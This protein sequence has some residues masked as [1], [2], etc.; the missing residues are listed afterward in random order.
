MLKKKLR[1]ILKTIAILIRHIG[2]SIKIN[3]NLVL[4]GAMDGGWYGDN[5]K[6]MFEFILKHAP[7]VKAYW[8]TKNRH[9]LKKLRKEGKPVALNYSIKGIYLLYRSRVALYTNSLLDISYERNLVPVDYQLIA[10]RHGRSV[11]RVR[12]ARKGHALPE[13][14]KILRKKEGEM[15]KYAIST[16]EL[17]SQIQEECLHIGIEKHII[18]G[19]PRNDYLKDPLEE[20]RTQFLRFVSELNYEKVILYGPSWR[21]GRNPTKYFPFDDFDREKLI[22]YLK[23]NKILLLIRP[24]M[25]DLNVKSE[26][27]KFLTQLARS[28]D[29]IKLATH[30]YFPDVNT[31][32]PFID[33]LVSDYSALYHDFLLLDKPM[34]FVP[35]DYD[36]F[37]IQNGFLYDYYEN[38][39][40]PK[41]STFKEFLEYTKIILTGQDPH[42]ENR[43][44][45]C[46]KIHTFNDNNSC[47]RVANL[48]TEIIHDNQ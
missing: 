15:I 44:A 8:I 42:K 6:Y 40:G 36:E 17:V 25:G 7:E 4:F 13:T 29:V 11:K 21:H 45:L 27:S 20:H 16:S 47:Q 2:T 34:M 41:I 3:P 48:L 22:S 43:K 32:L 5:S 24:H 46:S 28:N 12:F 31:L 30:H 10:L 23:T 38:L 26:V 1:S 35:Y 33:I 39:P 18:T 9:V 37:K 14:E 19:Y